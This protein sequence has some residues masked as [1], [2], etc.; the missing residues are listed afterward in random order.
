MEQFVPSLQANKEKYQFACKNIRIAIAGSDR[1]TGVTTTAMNLV[2]WIQE[3]GGTACYVEA[4][5]SKHLAHI[6]HLFDPEKSG[7]AYVMGNADFYLT[8]EFNQDYNFIVID[9]GVL[10]DPKLQELFSH[11]DV[12]LVCGSVMPYE[13]PIFYRA[14]ERCKHLPVHAVGMFVP[15]NL[16]PYLRKM[17]DQNII[18]GDSS[19]DLFDSNVNNQVHQQILKEYISKSFR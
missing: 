12:R 18:F 10:G 5:T 9:C 6:I 2:F 19:H 17:T 8:Q 13:L 7:N 4:N 14:L 15:E 11:A 16:K 3:H 1:R